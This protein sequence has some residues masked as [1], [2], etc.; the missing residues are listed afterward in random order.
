M[1]DS[2]IGGSGEKVYV[3]VL[4]CCRC[5]C[6][7]LMSLDDRRTRLSLYL[8]VGNPSP[9]SESSDS[10]LELAIDLVIS[11]VELGGS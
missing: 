10:I 7:V 11:D 4:K 5:W 2:I 6:L 9:C 8:D 3:E 1:T